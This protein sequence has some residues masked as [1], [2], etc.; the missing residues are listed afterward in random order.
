LGIAVVPRADADEVALHHRAGARER[1]STSHD[2]GA[3]HVLRIC[4]P[5]PPS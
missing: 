4:V 5:V 3:D 1:G 2:V